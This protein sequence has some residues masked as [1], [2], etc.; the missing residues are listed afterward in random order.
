MYL[1]A[2]Y[3]STFV[4]VEKLLEVAKPTHLLAF[5]QRLKSKTMQV[6]QHALCL[7]DFVLIAASAHFTIVYRC[8]LG[9]LTP[10]AI[11]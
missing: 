1:P 2:E 6:I 3:T 8:K 9:T 10:V 5:T 4:K 11:A 7:P